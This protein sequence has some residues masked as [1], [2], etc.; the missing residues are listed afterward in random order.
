MRQAIETKYLGPTNYRGARVKA[1]A[2]AGSI[3][4]PWDHTKDVADNHIA[5]AQALAAKYGWEGCYAGGAKVD[6]TGYCFVRVSRTLNYGQL[7]SVGLD[8]AFQC[9]CP[10]GAEAS[11]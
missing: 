8:M 2:Q 7:E 6:D 5:A 1:S 10:N 4:L 9:V 11:S 3:T